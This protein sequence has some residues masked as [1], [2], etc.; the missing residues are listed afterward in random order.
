MTKQELEQWLVSKGFKKD[1]YGHY[2]KIRED[3]TK[4]RVKLSNISAR[5]EKQITLTGYGKP[6]HEWLRIQSVY[7]KNLSI[8]DKGQLERKP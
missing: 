2:Q 1:T 4:I 3:G 6:V 8:N 5:Y 7:Y